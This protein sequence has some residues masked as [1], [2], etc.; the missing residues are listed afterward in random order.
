MGNVSSGFSSPELYSKS[1]DGSSSGASSGV[2][3]G[4]FSMQG[5]VSSSSGSFVAGSSASKDFAFDVFSSLSGPDRMMHEVNV[6]V[7]FS[8]RGQALVVCDSSNTKD[9]LLGLG[10][11]IVAAKLKPVFV[12][13]NHN[14]K[15]V[16]KWLND[17]GFFGN[18]VIIDTVS[19]SI[20]NVSDSKDV[21]FVDSLLNLT[22]LQIKILN[23]MVSNHNSFFVFDSLGIL[24]LYH[25]E[26]TAFR[27]IYSL[28]KLLHKEN[29]SGFFVSVK[30]TI[31]PKMSQF[32][33]E[34][35]ELKKMV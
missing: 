26:D 31:V 21:F 34:I 3:S 4:L 29:F 18:Y 7:P 25:D 12:L 20:V 23:V 10:K 16:G 32:F 15:T 13:F 14:Y 6:H 19:K 27:F 8:F 9:V 17:N 1:A 28:T 24:E 11:F 2:S 22:Q 30:K 33:D 35:I 5:D